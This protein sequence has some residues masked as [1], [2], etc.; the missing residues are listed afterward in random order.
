MHNQFFPRTV[1]EGWLDQNLNG[2]REK[3]EV[4]GFLGQRLDW[5]GVNYYTRF[6]VKG[7]RSLLAKV[8]AGIQAIPELMPNYG[9][10][11]KP[12][13][14][15]AD[16]KPVSDMGWEIYPEGLLESLRIMANYKRPLH[17]TKNGVADEKDKYR[18]NSLENM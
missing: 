16:G 3:G 2:I 9:V 1:V 11:C 4:K 15:S 8:F 7:K 12:N 5:L 18:P 14:I 6:V 10:A 17:M 13:C